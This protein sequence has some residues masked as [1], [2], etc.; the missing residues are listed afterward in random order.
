MGRIV[1]STE[2]AASFHLE[3]DVVYYMGQSSSYYL[4]Y[5]WQHVL[6]AFPF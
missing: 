6:H 4:V 2:E 5:F 1:P 3:I